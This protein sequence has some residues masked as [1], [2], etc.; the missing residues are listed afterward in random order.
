MS[1]THKKTDSDNVSGD[2]RILHV[3]VSQS[4][5][6]NKS[7]QNLSMNRYLKLRLVWVTRSVSFGAFICI[8][9]SGAHR[10]LGVH[11]SKVLSVNLDEWTHEEVNCVIKCGGNAIVNSKYEAC[12]PYNCRKPRPDS[13]IEERLEFI[14]KKYE[15]QQFLNSNKQICL[16]QC[17]SSSLQCASTNFIGAIMDK[18]NSNSIRMQSIGQAFRNSWRRKEAENKVPAKTSNSTAGMVEFIGLIKVNVV[19]G[20]NLAVRDMMTSDPYVILSLGNQ[21]VYDRDTFKA[22]DFMGDG[23]IDIQP[24]LSAA[25]ASEKSDPN[26]SSIELAKWVASKDNKDNTVAKDGVITLAKGVVKQEIALKLQ[27]VEKGV[28]QMELECVP[29]TQ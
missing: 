13:S 21:I 20:T 4:M 29:L 5:A 24:L 17:P 28:L 23:E 15:Q 2:D 8:K 22:D 27:N 14:R 12:I 11:I 16:Q 1:T 19:R 9:C 26:E 18:K 10:S 7:W 25:K 3:V 6:H